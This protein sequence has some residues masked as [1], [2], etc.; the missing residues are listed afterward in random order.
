MLN[1]T[2]VHTVAEKAVI[3]GIGY[4]VNVS[5]KGLPTPQ[6]LEGVTL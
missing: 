6:A 1:A 5:V 3:D 4:T 2:P